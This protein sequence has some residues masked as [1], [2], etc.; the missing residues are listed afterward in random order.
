MAHALI[1]QFRI[2]ARFGTT[3]LNDQSCRV[4]RITLHDMTFSPPVAK[5]AERLTEEDAIKIRVKA[6]EMGFPSIALAQAF[7]FE[8]PLLQR[9]VIGEWVPIS[10]PGTPSEIIDDDMKW[11]RGLRWSAID[12]NLTLRHVTSRAGQPL[13]LDLQKARMVRE[14]FARLGRDR[15]RT[16]TPVI[17]FEKSGLP[18]K[19]HQFRRL[20]RMIANEAGIPKTVKNMDSGVGRSE[21]GTPKKERESAR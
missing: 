20:W 7:Q 16:A 12:D 5:R 3:I 14:E 19:T 8:T 2:L 21:K 9:D 11:L 13:V 4:L 1:T 18:Y 10:E 6:H 15:P 17:V